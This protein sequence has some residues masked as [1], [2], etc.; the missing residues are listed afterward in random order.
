MKH[1]CNKNA[2]ALR[3][4][5]V[6]GVNNLQLEKNSGVGR[7]LM[8]TWYQYLRASNSYKIHIRFTKENNISEF[9][10][11]RASATHLT[12]RPSCIPYG[13]ATLKDSSGLEHFRG[14]GSVA[15]GSQEQPGLWTF[16]NLEADLS[17]HFRGFKSQSWKNGAHGMVHIAIIIQITHLKH[18]R[19]RPTHTAIDN[20]TRTLLKVCHTYQESIYD[21]TELFTETSAFTQTTVIELFL[22]AAESES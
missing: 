2:M 14:R 9:I 11:V 13:N 21:W 6:D 3:K 8:Q 17:S 1:I 7:Q 16:A 22:T 12:T 10:K 5:V 19:N 15:S 4:N 20:D 18:H